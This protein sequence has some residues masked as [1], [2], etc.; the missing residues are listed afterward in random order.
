[1]CRRQ[2]VF[3]WILLALGIGLLLG[4]LLR[5]RVIQCCLG[6]GLIVAGFCLLRKK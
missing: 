5:S 1:M 4:N 6:I 2:L 3:G